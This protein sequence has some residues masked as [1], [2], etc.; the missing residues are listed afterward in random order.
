M[1]LRMALIRL[2]SK[3]TLSLTVPF[4]DLMNNVRDGLT[5]EAKNGIWLEVSPGHHAV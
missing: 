3:H 4:G 1:E 2:V 5:I